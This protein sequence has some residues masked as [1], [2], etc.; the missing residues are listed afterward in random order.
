MGKSAGL[1][2]FWGVVVNG[3]S[4]DHGGWRWDWKRWEGWGLGVGGL[5]WFFSHPPGFLLF[6]SSYVGTWER[7]EDLS[8]KKK[9]KIL[10]SSGHPTRASLG[11]R[12]GF[13]VFRGEGRP[14]DESA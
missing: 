8:N 1:E 2:Y 9:K 10:F 6:L 7:K 12:T 4:Q 11:T 3:N 13:L 5:D 14:T